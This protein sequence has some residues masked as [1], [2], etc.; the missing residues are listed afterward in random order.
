MYNADSPS[1]LQVNGERLAPPLTPVAGLSITMNSRRVQ[2]T[3]DFDLTVRFDRA[4]GVSAMP[5]LVFNAGKFVAV[6][7][8]TQPMGSEQLGKLTPFWLYTKKE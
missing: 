7:N 6:H 4:T 8:P 3:T 5:R 2:L 1:L